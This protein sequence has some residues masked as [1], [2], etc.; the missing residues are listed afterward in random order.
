VVL[1][2]QN[3]RLLVEA[4]PLNKRILIIDDDPRMLQI[5]GESFAG[6][7]YQVD[8]A[9]DGEQ[10]LARFVAEPP[11]VVVTDIL[12]PNREGVETILAMKKLRAGTKIVAISGG[13]QVGASSFLTLASH[14]GAD[15]VLA[16]PF[17][18]AEIRRLVD[19]LSEAPAVVGA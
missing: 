16:K 1:E 17:R 14:V 12:M 9:S 11:E 3:L 8:L 4:R 10:G 7:G 6:S 18:F 13:G 5:L 2:A 15:A 19:G